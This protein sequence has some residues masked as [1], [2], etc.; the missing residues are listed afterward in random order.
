MRYAAIDVGSNAVRLLIADINQEGKE[1]TYKKNTFIRVPL[2]LGDDAF[3]DKRIG[4]RKADELVKTMTAFKL[5]MDVYK[6]S[7]Y[8]ACATSAMREAE[9]GGE[10]T[11]RIMKEGNLDLQIVEGQTEANIIYSTHI[12]ESLE[13]DKNYLYIDVGGGST[14]LSIFTKGKVEVS[15]SFSIGTVRMLDNADTQ[16]EWDEMNKWIKANTRIYKNLIGIGTGGNINK[17]FRLSN[18]KDGSPLS[19]SVLNDM[20]LNLRS[21]SLK[22]RI[23]L[24]KLNPDRA[25]VIVP[26]SE[27][28]LSVMKW[29]SVKQ[30]YVPR[31]G[32][33]DGIIQVLIDKN[34]KS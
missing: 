25:D 18:Q 11:R 5:L 21:Y 8:M 13:L 6:V 33:A 24:M 14:E 9:N 26:A 16:E 17:L 20:Y 22:E 2:R 23:T 1:I 30:I 10:I 4:E 28:Y 19:F 27:I 7:D 29:A 15:R 31:V 12:A 3:I 34:L 32:M